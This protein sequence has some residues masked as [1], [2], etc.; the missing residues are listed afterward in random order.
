MLKNVTLILRNKESPGLQNQSCKEKSKKDSNSKTQKNY[1]Y[2]VLK[3]E[4][5]RG[6]RPIL[7]SGDHVFLRSVGKSLDFEPF[8]VSCINLNC[9]F[10]T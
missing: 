5:V 7:F 2:V 6:K 8:H 4:K 3:I 10:L 1:P 9:K